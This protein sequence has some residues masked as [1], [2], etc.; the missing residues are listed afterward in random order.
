[1]ST[2]KKDYQAV[3]TALVSHA[4]VISTINKITKIWVATEDAKLKVALGKLIEHLKNGA[5]KQS[6]PKAIVSFQLN[7]T[8]YKEITAYCQNCIQSIKPQ[9]Q[10]IAEQHGWV[11]SSK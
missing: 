8:P 3:L 2:D 4:T 1:M 6:N 7:V 11:P 10:I 9:W 5:E